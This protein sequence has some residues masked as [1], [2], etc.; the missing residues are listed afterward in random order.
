MA[1]ARAETFHIGEGRTYNVGPFTLAF[2]TNTSAYTVAEA[3]CA[4]GAGTGLH[5][6]NNFDQV[7]IV[8]EGRCE[9]QL[10]DRTEFL[11][12]GD[13]V[14]LPRGIVHGLTNL[15]PG[16]ARLLVITSPAGLLETFVAEVATK[17]DDSS[18][19]PGAN[20]NFRIVASKHGLEW[21][22]GDNRIWVVGGE[23]S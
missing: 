19:G 21:L 6:H 7:Q 23:A 18:A 3:S 16:L 5:R 10:E 8:L 4:G 14:F 20:A 13:S 9:V 15:G 22:E 2:K 12:A 11:G 17:R 1:N